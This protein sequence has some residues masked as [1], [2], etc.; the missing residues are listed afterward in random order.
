MEA[1]AWE[2]P[3]L[4]E[5][6]E[7][8]YMH[9]GEMTSADIG[10]NGERLGFEIRD[11]ATGKQGILAHKQGKCPRLGSYHANLEDLNKIGVEAARNV[12]SSELIVIDGIAPVE[13]S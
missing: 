9:Y 7:T 10:V 11:G 2:N 8:T 3:R 12:M 5:C 13:N 1:R 4:E 6:F